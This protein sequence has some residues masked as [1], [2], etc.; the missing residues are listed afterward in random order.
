MTMTFSEQPRTVVILNDRELPESPPLLDDSGIAPQWLDQ[1]QADA[2]GLRVVRESAVSVGAASPVHQQA[3]TTDKRGRKPD[4]LVRSARALVTII[5]EMGGLRA[6]EE[7]AQAKNDILYRVQATELQK[8]Q[9]HEEL[10]RRLAESGIHVLVIVPSGY[11]ESLM[12]LQRGIQGSSG[13]EPGVAEEDSRAE[14]E[15]RR[16]LIVSNSADDRSAAGLVRIRRA[17]SVWE[18][19]IRKNL[20]DAAHLPP[21]LQNPAS[22]SW[23]EVAREEQVAAQH[24]E[25]AV[26]GHARSYVTHRRVLSGN[27]SWRWRKRTRHDGDAADLTGSTD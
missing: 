18:S 23:L 22:L 8:E 12:T 24:L 21:Q 1:G 15:G 17:L 20:F 16:I 19:A 26:S 9:L 25:Q 2:A 13:R 27:R 4:D 7:T 3:S 14:S 11:R 10:N 6:I 5:D